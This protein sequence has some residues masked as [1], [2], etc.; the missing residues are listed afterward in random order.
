VQELATLQHVCYVLHDGLKVPVHLYNKYWKWEVIQKSLH[1][2]THTHTHRGHIGDLGSRLG[3]QVK[4]VAKC[5]RK[6]KLN[7]NSVK[8]ERDL[9]N[10]YK[11]TKVSLFQF[12]CA[13]GG[14]MIII[15]PRFLKRRLG[16][17]FLTAIL[18]PPLHT[19][20]SSTCYYR[21][22]EFFNYIVQDVPFKTQP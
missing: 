10:T 5:R 19:H 8:N 17:Q 12:T 21:C 11:T 15:K 9:T 20:T 7:K 2:H 6:I 3:R 1:T 16:R 18:G 13:Y 4:W 14:N 22:T